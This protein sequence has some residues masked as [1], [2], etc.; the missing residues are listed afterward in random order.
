MSNHKRAQKPAAAPPQAEEAP[1]HENPLLPHAKLRQIYLTML[2]CEHWERRTAPS[3]RT[4]RGLEAVLSTLVIDLLPTDR[5]GPCSLENELRIVRGFQE[6]ARTEQELST[7]KSAPGSIAS[8][9]STKAKQPRPL[10]ESAQWCF[11]TG[12]ALAQKLSGC[13]GAAVLL[14]RC[15]GKGAEGCQQAL[16]FAAAHQLPM[17][18][19]IWK[20]AGA[21]RASACAAIVRHAHTCGIPA[22]TVDGTDAVGMYRVVQECLQRARNGDGP[23]LIECIASPGGKTAP[24]AGPLSQME[25]YLTSKR[26]F[27]KEWKREQVA[28]LATPRKHLRPNKQRRLQATNA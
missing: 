12:L 26:L 25:R 10:P 13:G 16:T 9:R 23:T 19:A 3:A 22:I 1:S 18:Y 20:E 8:P 21:A 24:S 6:S 4:M 17:L 7:G 27:T 28:L 15:P 5:I 14:S 2:Q 11:S